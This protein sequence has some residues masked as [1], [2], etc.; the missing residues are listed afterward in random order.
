MNCPKCK[1][2]NPDDN[3]I[4]SGCG[5]ELTN[6]AQPKKMCSLALWSFTLTLCTPALI[7]LILITDFFINR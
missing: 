6:S 2:Q 1:I 4:C 5:A 3:T 7:F